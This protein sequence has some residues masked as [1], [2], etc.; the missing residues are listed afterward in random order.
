MDNNQIVDEIC[1]QNNMSLSKQH[2]DLPHLK[3]LNHSSQNELND[4][5]TKIDQN[6]FKDFDYNNKVNHKEM[7]QNESADNHLVEGIPVKTTLIDEENKKLK[8]KKQQRR[9][10]INDK[11]KQAQHKL[12]PK[13]RGNENAE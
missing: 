8:S 5:L 1:K 11:I 7:L 10:S 12:P 13:T 9:G 3:S 6:L 4:N 2:Y